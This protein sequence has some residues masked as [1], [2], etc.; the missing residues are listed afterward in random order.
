MKFHYQGVAKD[1][2]EIIY[3]IRILFK[4]KHK[5]MRSAAD[6]ER[7]APDPL[8]SR[9]EIRLS[10]KQNLIRTAFSALIPSCGLGFRIGKI[11]RIW[12]RNSGDMAQTNSNF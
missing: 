3:M 10:K 4:L 7:F 12:V 8:R 2:Q 9:I 11:M 5:I 1:F 6:P